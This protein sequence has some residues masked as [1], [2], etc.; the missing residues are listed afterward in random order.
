VAA[1]SISFISSHPRHAFPNL[2]RTTAVAAPVFKSQCK[3][4]DISWNF[5]SR[6]EYYYG[7]D[8][9]AKEQLVEPDDRYHIKTTN[10]TTTA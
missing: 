7:N 4:H 5:H 2:Q 8:Y 6:R 1:V 3:L 9:G 10:T